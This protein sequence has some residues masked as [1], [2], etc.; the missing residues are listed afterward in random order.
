[1]GQQAR[2]I[3]RIE[4]QAAECIAGRVRAEARGGCG[5]GCGEPAIE[6]FQLRQQASQRFGCDQEGGIIHHLRRLI[7]RLNRQ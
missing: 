1:M 5:R 4:M 7:Q 2:G 3:G 6:S